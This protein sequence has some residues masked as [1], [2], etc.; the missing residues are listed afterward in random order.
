MSQIGNDQKT[1]ELEE[2][3]ENN[4]NEEREHHPNSKRNVKE[5]LKK[6]YKNDPIIEESEF[7]DNTNKVASRHLETRTTI[8]YTGQ[9][10]KQTTDDEMKNTGDTRSTMS[11]EDI[12]NEFKFKKHQFR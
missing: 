4:G 10:T 12:K 9:L 11:R 7:E 3:I 5:L 1:I 8:T 6:Y 2:K